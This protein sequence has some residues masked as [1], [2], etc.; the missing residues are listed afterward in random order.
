[1]TAG[2]GTRSRAPPRALHRRRRFYPSMV[3]L[4]SSRLSVA[5]LGNLGFALAFGAY[6]ITTLV[7]ETERGQASASEG[8]TTC[9]A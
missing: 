9:V 3:Y 1:M 7:S 2:R 6:K 5:I 8:R 4:S